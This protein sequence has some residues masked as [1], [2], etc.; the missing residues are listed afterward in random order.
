MP[1]STC[2]WRTWDRSTPAPCWRIT[3]ASAAASGPTVSTSSTGR[4]A[5]IPLTDLAG[6]RFGAAEQVEGPA[7]HRATLEVPEPADS[8]LALPGWTKGQVWLNSFALGR[9]W[10]RGPQRTLYAP[11]PVWRVGLNELVILELHR[12]G[13]R[14]ELC[15]VADLD[16][17]DPGPTG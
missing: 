1:N 15:D 4:S 7:F 2:W 17:T 12:P 8:F 5:P 6:Q 16:P 13:E 14:I 10:E 9:Y 3:R 11:A